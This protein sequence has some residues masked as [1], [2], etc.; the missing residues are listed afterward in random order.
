MCDKEFCETCSDPRASSL[1]EV[2]AL[3]KDLGDTSR[4]AMDNGQYDLNAEGV[5]VF[6]ILLQAHLNVVIA[7]DDQLEAIVAE[8]ERMIKVVNGILANTGVDVPMTN[9][10]GSSA[11]N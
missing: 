6:A 7:P 2:L 3:V 4:N 1:N 9:V 11:V 8:R 5:M 10:N